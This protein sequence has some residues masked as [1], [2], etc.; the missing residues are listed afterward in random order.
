L[1]SSIGALAIA[2]ILVLG[3][4]SPAS[5]Y[6]PF[7]GTDAA[8]AQ[9]RR[10]ETEFS[11]I[12]YVRVADERTLVIPELALSYGAGSN[13]EFVVEGRRVMV[14]SSEAPSPR[15]DDITVSVK[16][17]LR[18]GELQDATGPSIATEDGVLLPTS[19]DRGAGFEGALIVSQ[20]W[21]DVALHLN[22]A[23]SRTRTHET[24]RFASLI[25][26]GPERWTVRPVAEVTLEREG[27][28]PTER[29]LLIGGLWETREHLV[30]DLGFKIAYGEEREAEVRVGLTFNKHVPHGPKMP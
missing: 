14:M 29:G 25:A 22:G 6:R 30:M 7:D 13:W 11:P 1:N 2:L 21:P 17:V 26:T 10:L 15:F 3:G 16:R 19:E 24:G 4:A 9:P 18:E 12:G 5:A 8:V 23:I 27:E 20:V 28:A